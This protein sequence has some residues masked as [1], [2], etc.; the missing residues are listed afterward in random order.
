LEPFERRAKSLRKARRSLEQQQQIQR[1]RDITHNPLDTGYRL[2][3]NKSTEWEELE[4]FFRLCREEKS[5]VCISQYLSTQPALI[6]DQLICTVEVERIFPFLLKPT[7][8][9]SRLKCRQISHTH[10]FFILRPLKLEEHSLVPYIAVFHDFMSDAETEIFKSLAVERLE[11]SA[12]GSK[13]SG[14][15][16]VTSDKRTSKQ[17]D[18]L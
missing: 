11:R 14:Q 17:Y 16:G 8:L 10:S 3:T 12:H 1:M 4:V 2:A 15:G 7:G 18:I 5:L 13:R 6:H 9:K